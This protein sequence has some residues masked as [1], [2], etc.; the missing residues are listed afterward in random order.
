MLLLRMKI[1]QGDMFWVATMEQ[2][3]SSQSRAHPHVVIQEDAIN[4]SRVT[5]VVTCALTTNL[6]RAAWPGNV[7]LAAGE[8]NLEKSSVVLVSQVQAVEKSALGEHIGTLSGERMTQILRG[9]RF[10]QAMLESRG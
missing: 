5:T 2:G 9:M 10:L 3:D 7:L 8:G 1:K 4:Q 6:K